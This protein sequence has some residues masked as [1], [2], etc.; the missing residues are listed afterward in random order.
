MNYDKYLEV[1]QKAWD[2]FLN[3]FAQSGVDR[4]AVENALHN[5]DAF[6]DVQ[7]VILSV[8][9]LECEE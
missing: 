8:V 7:D 3:I 4:K 6:N 9:R 5:R 2:N 1:E